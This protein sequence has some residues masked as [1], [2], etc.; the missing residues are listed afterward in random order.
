MQPWLLATG[1]F[2]PDFYIFHF[3]YLHGNARLNLDLQEAC[4]LGWRSEPRPE[5]EASGGGKRGLG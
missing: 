3:F 5:M 4:D 2:F 1:A